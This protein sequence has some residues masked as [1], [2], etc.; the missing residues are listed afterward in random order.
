MVFAVRKSS[1]GM[2]LR[3]ILHG[4]QRATLTYIWHLYSGEI[5]VEIL[6]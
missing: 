1:S 6:I 3:H 5:D 2:K 4:Y